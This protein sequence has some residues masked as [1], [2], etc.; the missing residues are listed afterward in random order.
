MLP[1]WHFGHSKSNYKMFCPYRSGSKVQ[2]WKLYPKVL[3]ELARV[4]KQNTG[5]AC[6]LTQDKKC[7]LQVRFKV[8]CQCLPWLPVS[9]LSILQR[10][11]G[12]SQWVGNT[13]EFLLR[14]VHQ[15]C[16][17]QLFETSALCSTIAESAPD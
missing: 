1:C 10:V 9:V 15:G 2:N 17:I 11:T 12:S 6:L 5:R 16:A 4:C 7:I 14:Q 8:N 3:G 13:R